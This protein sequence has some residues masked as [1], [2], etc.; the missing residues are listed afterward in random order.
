MSINK[1]MLHLWIHCPGKSNDVTKLVWEP[2]YDALYL[3][4][5]TASVRGM[6]WMK[7]NA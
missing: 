3:K 2:V 7:M 5:I 6:T 1:R 4:P